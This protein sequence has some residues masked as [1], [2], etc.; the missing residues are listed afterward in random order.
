MLPRIDDLS[1]AV[2]YG[3]LCSLKNHFETG[4]PSSPATGG[5]PRQTEACASE[6]QFFG[7]FRRTLD[8][9]GNPVG[10]EETAKPEA[11]FDG[12]INDILCS[13]GGRPGS[14]KGRSITGC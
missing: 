4:F 14:S 7:A 13:K 8:S 1:P 11:G 10:S 5:R 6:P 3:C 9:F 12:L 2:R